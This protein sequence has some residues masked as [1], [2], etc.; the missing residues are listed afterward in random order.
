MLA[1]LVKKIVGTKNDREIKRYCR[2]V[3]EINAL[4]PSVAA[5]TDAELREKRTGSERAWRRDFPG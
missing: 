4:E 1:Y 3:E 5:L 2:S